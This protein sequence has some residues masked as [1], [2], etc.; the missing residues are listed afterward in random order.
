MMQF[1]GAVVTFVAGA[2]IA[3]RAG[4][5]GDNLVRTYNLAPI[6]DLYDET[7]GYMNEQLWYLPDFTIAILYVLTLLLWSLSI[8]NINLTLLF[9]ELGILYIIRGIACRLTIGYIS[10]RG[11][12]CRG[13][14]QGGANCYISDLVISGHT[15]TAS[16]L[17]YSVVDVCD[18]NWLVIIY[19]IIWVL[20]VSSNLFVGDH[21]SSDVFLG[22]VLPWLLHY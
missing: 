15:M 6:Y 10:R 13:A 8:L 12:T 4:K 16:V 22:L 2:L 14:V 19:T 1:I 18:S 20:S 9:Y 21:Y 3:D 7:I 5:F 11:I 17:F